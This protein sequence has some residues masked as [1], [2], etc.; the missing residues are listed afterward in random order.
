MPI[1]AIYF[2]EKSIVLDPFCGVA[3]TL[4]ACSNLNRKFIGI[5]LDKRYFDI[6]LQRTK[7]LCNSNPE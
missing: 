6:G 4:I 1:L 5:E 7:N 3:S 2:P